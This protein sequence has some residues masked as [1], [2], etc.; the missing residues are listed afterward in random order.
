M[1][2]FW[3]GARGACA[4]PPQQPLAISAP[5]VFFGGGFRTTT[6]TVY[7]V[8]CI[9]SVARSYSVSR[10][11]PRIVCFAFVLFVATRCAAMFNLN[12]YSFKWYFFLSVCNRCSNSNCISWVFSHTNLAFFLISL[13]SRRVLR[14]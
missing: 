10:L 12:I 8:H 5:F 9:F 2:T 13:F 14:S 7:R 1:R 6:T 11:I 4:R 3:G